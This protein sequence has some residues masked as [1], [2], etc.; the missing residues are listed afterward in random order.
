MTNYVSAIEPGDT[1]FGMHGALRRQTA[2]VKHQ[3]VNPVCFD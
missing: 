2:L 1:Q 3:S